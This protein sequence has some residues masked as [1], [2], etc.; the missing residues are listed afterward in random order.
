VGEVIS[1]RKAKFK[2]LNRRFHR[3]GLTGSACWGA[4]VCQFRFDG[5]QDSEGLQKQVAGKLPLDG[6]GS[7]LCSAESSVLV[8]SRARVACEPAGIDTN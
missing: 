7:M 4:P 3:H 6:G 5:A 1:H 8:A 2:I